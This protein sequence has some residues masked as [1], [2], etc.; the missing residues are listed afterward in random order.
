M[1]IN[2]K[3]ERKR[4]EAAEETVELL[5]G[6]VDQA[7]RGVGMLQKQE[8]E[9]KR[10]S[11][12]PGSALG[13]VGS[14][15]TEELLESASM[16][17]A[18][19]RASFIGGGGRGHRRASSN[20][21]PDVIVSGP[22][23]PT[24]YT[25]PN[26]DPPKT[27]GLRELRLGSLTNPPAGG[28]AV[29]SPV[30]SHFEMIDHP[31]AGGG[32]M[33]T[34]STSTVNHTSPPKDN[35]MTALRSELNNLRVQLSESEE[36]RIASEVCLKALRDFMASGGEGQPPPDEL[37]RELRLP[38]L[39]SDPEPAE[40]G[41]QSKKAGGTGGTGWGFKLW[42]GQTSPSASTTVEP[43][44]T[45]GSLPAM[46]AGTPHVSPLPTPGELS[47]AEGIVQ[48]VPTSQTPLAS[49]VSGWTKGV[50]PGTPAE[51]PSGAGRKLTGLF[52]RGGAKKDDKDLLPAPEGDE[53]AATV[54][55]TIT[56]L[57]SS[58][59]G[60]EPSPDIVEL[61]AQAEVGACD[62]LTEKNI[63]NQTSPEKAA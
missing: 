59:D 37:L 52:S 44:G 42:R 4:R 25:S 17:K 48:A 8:K 9:R 13:L 50:V 56:G 23:R 30:G 1:E 28:S 62:D 41:E 40:V 26:P 57:R 39:P 12:L 34:P 24:P 43:P 10:M 29:I 53:S 18:S 60:L 32:G 49:F 38:P 31:V 7:R 22:S 46:P 33:R 51:R 6:Q 21:E 35:E 55:P 5:R 47:V 20:S 19:K 16:S 36:N 54:A 27:G 58:A 45:P 61:T 11:Y 15:D 63:S 14:V 2:L 3:N